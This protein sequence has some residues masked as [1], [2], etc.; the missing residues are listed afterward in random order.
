[1]AWYGD[2]WARRE[3]LLAN[4]LLVLVRGARIDPVTGFI[5]VYLDA[6]ESDLLRSN[7][8]REF[9]L[10][11]T[12]G[13]ASDYFDG[14]AEDAVARINQRWCGR[15]VRLRVAWVGGGGSIQLS[16]AD[17]LAGDPDVRW[18]HRRGHYGNGVRVKPRG[19]HVSL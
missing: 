6:N 16:D 1:M 17:P 4:G 18:L 15:L 13:Y 7:A 14:V 5:A 3:R 12:I 9:E 8:D 19:L 10:H 2:Y 11:L